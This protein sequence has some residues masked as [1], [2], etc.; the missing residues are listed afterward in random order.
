MEGFRN[1][2]LSLV[3]SLLENE[4]KAQIEVRPL[5]CL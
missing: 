4:L 5:L 2:G 3:V 1:L